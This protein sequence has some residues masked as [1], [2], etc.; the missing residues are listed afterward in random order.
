MFEKIFE[1]N[2]YFHA[3][4]YIIRY[5]GRP[6]RPTADNKEFSPKFYFFQKIFIF[7]MNNYKIK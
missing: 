3:K 2:I 1:E 7:I 5:L 4:F 6:L